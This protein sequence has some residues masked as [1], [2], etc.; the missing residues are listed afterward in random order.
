VLWGLTDGLQGGI[1][2]TQPGQ[3]RGDLIGEDTIPPELL[4]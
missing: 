4:V 3:H 2:I 1:P